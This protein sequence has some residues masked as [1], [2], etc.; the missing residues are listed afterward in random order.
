MS[1][2]N[3][4]NEFEKD[5]EAPLR[6]VFEASM[7]KR[8]E[9]KGYKMSDLVFDV[10]RAQQACAAILRKHEE[11]EKRVEALENKRAKK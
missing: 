9:E 1:L 7:L 8:I 4:L 5:E 10:F 3:I 2:L 11:L 6:A